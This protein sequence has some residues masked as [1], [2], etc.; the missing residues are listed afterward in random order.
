MTLDSSLKP[1]ADAR[2][3]IVDRLTTIDYQIGLRTPWSNELLKHGFS[4]RFP[5]ITHRGL[6]AASLNG[7]S[8]NTSSET[9]FEW[10]VDKDRVI[11]MFTRRRV[12]HGQD[13]LEKN[14]IRW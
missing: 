10:G 5:E 9:E 13:T 2:E 3:L 4:S 1:V 7:V 8:L 6:R 12:R 14:D 11:D